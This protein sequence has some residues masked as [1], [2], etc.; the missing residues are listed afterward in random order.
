MAAPTV[1]EP[2]PAS[3]ETTTASRYLVVMGP[4][5]TTTHQLPAEGTVVIGRAEDAPIR[6]IDPQA[7]RNHARLHIAEVIEVEDLASANGTRIRDQPLAPGIRVALSP[8][9]AITIGSTVLIV[10]TR[11]PAFKQ[12]QLRPHGYLESR[13]IEECARAEGVRGTFALVRLQL[14]AAIAVERAAEVVTTSL[15]PGDVLAVYGPH[16]LE[17]L[18]V[19]SDRPKA[20]ALRTQI[21]EALEREGIGSRSGLAFYPADGTSPQALV[22]HACSLVLGA[23]GAVA[24][25][26]GIVLCNEAMRQ[27][28]A[29]AELA[30]AGTINVLIL[31]D[32]G[33]GKEVL[34]HTV[35]E[36]SP[37]ASGPFVA[38]NCAALTDALLDSELFGHERGAFTGAVQAKTGL[39]EAASGGSLFLD[40]LGEMS[41]PLQAK[42]LRAIDTKEVLRVGATRPRAVDV[43]FIAATNR[44]IEEEVAAKTFR[45]DLYFRLSGMTLTIPPLR[46]RTDEIEPLA[47][48][49]LENTARQ[50]GRPAPELS[51]EALS[52]LKA[53]HW[54]GNIRELRNVIER[55][56]LLAG[57][58]RITGAHLPA[59]KPRIAEVE[60]PSV[61]AA[62][63]PTRPLR[64]RQDDLE[65]QAILD[66]L[67]R[68]A[69][70][71]TRAAELLG[72]PRRT[73]CA[74]LKKYG[75]DGP[76]G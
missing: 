33:V 34:A 72:M 73:F 49:F 5:V 16:D 59:D 11:E 64:L 56:L 32:N 75:I 35:H 4:N 24:P 7:S 25:P 69:G 3:S 51:S 54:P 57:G 9:E 67:A 47:R 50:L 18:L 52:W 48:M 42:L 6:L 68:C 21:V 37:R 36:R 23:E 39:L 28:Y 30:A 76:R 38:V 46:E 74:R 70:N 10:R 71:Q 44:D 15:R 26:G 13:L 29:Q 14:P 31:G 60:P 45:R 20:E 65:R 2:R 12:P 22:T 53:Y 63:E 43:R 55:A 27:L 66:A 58:G 40:E 61:A 8:G 17:L 19:D 41:L 1:S 62:P